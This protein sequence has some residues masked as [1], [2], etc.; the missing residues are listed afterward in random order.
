MRKPFV[1]NEKDRE[2]LRSFLTFPYLTSRQ[3]TSLHYS[4]GSASYV[5]MRLPW[6][7]AEGYL[8]R[9]EDRLTRYYPYLYSLALRGIRVLE[10][11]P[12]FYPL[13]YKR[14]H[15][16]Q[17]PHLLLTNEVL[18]SS[19]KLRRVCEGIMIYSA[20]HDFALKYLLTTAIPDA[21]VVI[22]RGT[23]FFPICFE[24]HITTGEAK[25]K[26]K[27]KAILESVRGEYFDVFKTR[28]VTWSFLTPLEEEL[29]KMILWT[30]EE[31]LRLGEEREADL[32]RFALIPKSDIDPLILFTKPMHRI[33][34]SQKG[35]V[36]ALLPN[37]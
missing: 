10:D 27:I 20:Q 2:I 16:I 36:D 29:P 23:D 21:R 14:V 30:Q 18:I 11:K 9:T 37:S 24:I 3:V 1:F 33:P 12:I 6:L 22:G 7:V 28:A 25:F 19:L 8:H 4:K 17:Y 34:F 31:L 26:R 15:P 5:E 32:F 13:P 35:F